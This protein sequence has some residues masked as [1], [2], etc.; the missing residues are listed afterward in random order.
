MA[1]GADKVFRFDP[2]GAIGLVDPLAVFVLRFNEVTTEEP[3]LD[4]KHVLNDFT[5][6]TTLTPEVATGSLGRAREFDGSTTG[7][8]STDVVTGDTLLTRDM[9]IQVA[10]SWDAAVQ[11]AGAPGFIIARGVGGSSSEYVSYGLRIEALDAPSYTARVRWFW[12]DVA[13]VDRLQDGADV[14]ILPGTFTMLTA[15]RRWVSPT[16]VVLCYYVGDQ[17]LAEV[18]SVNGSIGGG[19]TG[20]MLLGH[21][22][23]GGVD[24]NFFAGRLD[25]LLVVSR[26]LCFEEVEAT[27]LRITK[28]QPLGV[29][30][31][32]EMMDDGFPLS[33]QGDSDAQLDIRIKGHAYGFAAAQI[34]NLRANFLPGRAYGTTLEQWEEA[35]RVTPAPAASIQQR[36]ARVLA[37][38]AQRRGVSIPG[39]EDALQGLLGGATV[40]DLEYLAFNSIITEAFDTINLLRWDVTPVAS[41]TAVSGAARSSLAAGDYT[42]DGFNSGWQYARM[43]V[44][45][46][47]K[48]AHAIA[49]VA[50]TTPQS[51]LEVGV[52]FGDS[53]LNNF[54]LLGLRDNAGS[55][56]VVT[57]SYVG[58]VPSAAVVQVVLGANP[59]NLWL[60]LY[61]TETDGTWTPAWSTTSKIAGYTLGS[62]VTH[63]SIAR[64]SGV[65]VRSTAAIA[66]AAV[67]D[68]PDFELF[69][70]FGQR[71]FNAYVLLDR[72]LGFSPDI[73]AAQS[74]L[75]GI[76]HGYTHVAFITSREFLC[77]DPESGC[78]RGPMGAL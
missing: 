1:Y 27:W 51:G 73:A 74:V 28:Y 65:Y 22:R 54:I 29:Q 72:A 21:R 16:E 13:G 17:L 18:T 5:A 45:G 78:D 77:D 46:D 48:A 10:L 52:Y 50:Q 57:Q 39:V 59:A 67:V 7:L 30:L 44:G 75:E 20:T 9:S 12:Q 49:K 11:A 42:F 71:P 41:W 26:E 2:P 37:R 69:E 23:A 64:W 47:A 63:P 55:F 4:D 53:A 61:Q 43:T 25:E 6:I 58:G 68:V 35:F 14:V 76:K 24:G 3:P 56:E 15:T 32:L 60:H 34:E 66:G 31:Y 62:N 70:P 40:D 8:R 36:R 19:T 38:L 33:D